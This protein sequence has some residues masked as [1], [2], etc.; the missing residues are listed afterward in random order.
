[1]SA[2]SYGG[3]A[4]DQMRTLTAPWSTSE[5]K[6]AFYRQIAQADE[7]FTDE[8]QERYA[9]ISLPVKIIW[10]R[11]DTVVPVDRAERLAQMIPDSELEIIDGAGHLI[12]YDAPA[13]LAV[14][15]HRW[16][17]HVSTSS[18]PDMQVG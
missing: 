18:G 9:E 3:L 12:Q 10:G 15:L 5:G 4:P 6:A 16:L 11:E 17:R 8:I 7:R 14:A 2:A 1:V 13:Q